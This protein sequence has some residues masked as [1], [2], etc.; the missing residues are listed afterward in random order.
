VYIGLIN[1]SSVK[2]SCSEEKKRKPVVISKILIYL[3]SWAV[4]RINIVG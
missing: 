1:K 2:V 4:T 3:S